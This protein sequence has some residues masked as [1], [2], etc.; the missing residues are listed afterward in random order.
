NDRRPVRRCV[1][2]EFPDGVAAG[3]GTV[4]S[5]HR[6]KRNGSRGDGRVEERGTRWPEVREVVW[7]REH[8]RVTREAGGGVAETAGRR[9]GGA[10][11]YGGRRVCAAEGRGC[12]IR[13]RRT[14]PGALAH[15]LE[16][17]RRR[18]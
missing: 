4:P 13:E 11:F 14:A 6:T 10:L 3:E 9:R 1:R 5:G 7:S 16:C 8:S 15:R 17:G 18:V 2:G 12:D